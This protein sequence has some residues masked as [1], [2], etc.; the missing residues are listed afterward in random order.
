M[1]FRSILIL[2]KS[3][4]LNYIV[5]NSLSRK[6]NYN[7]EKIWL[8][9]KE[10]LKEGMKISLNN[11]KIENFIYLRNVKTVLL[12]AIL[13]NY[14]LKSFSEIV[15]KIEKDFPKKFIKKNIS[16]Y[17]KLILFLIKNKLSILLYILLIIRKKIL[18]IVK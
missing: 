7:V 16:I 5:P 10:I 9:M 2:N 15:Q 6:K 8:G 11:S 4:Y 1:L 3:L 13:S 12:L 17:D 14:S 18:I